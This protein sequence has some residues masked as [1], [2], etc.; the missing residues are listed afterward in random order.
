MTKVY[1]GVV[2]GCGKVGATFE[3][4]S[5]LLKPAS[6]AAALKA[7]PRT[8]LVGLVDPDDAQ[9]KRA[10]DY[11]G[12]KGYKDAREAIVDLKP[13]IVTVSTPPGTH[14]E[15]VLLCI[16]LGVPLIV[17]EKPVADTLEAAERMIAA[18][19]GSKSVVLVNHQRR[20]F[21]LYKEAR[22]RIAAGEFGRIQQVSAYY[23]NGFF[24]NGTHAIDAIRFLLGDD[25]AWA[26]GV[27]N[28][29]N[30]TAPFGTNID[31]LV[32]FTK[33]AVLALQSFDNAHFSP[34][35]IRIMGE[36][37]ALLIPHHGF[38]F[39]YVPVR[40]GVTFAG[41]KELDWDAA[42]VKTERRSMLEGTI[43][44]AVECLEGGAPQSTLED[45]YKTMQVLEAVSQSATKEST[46]III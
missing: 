28:P 20:F 34:H 46:K 11:Y 7:N 18:A 13:D 8:E 36:K 2:I 30:T 16:E 24:N 40:E 12:A 1:K 14:E 22:E 9:L 17:C 3:M 35:E 29:L 38:V 6:H 25:A 39:E 37:G 21:S 15:Y 41:M 32:G 45:G 44:H 43:A 23:S 42:D 31:A 10:T 4:D 26:I 27:E 19:K 5:G 33:G